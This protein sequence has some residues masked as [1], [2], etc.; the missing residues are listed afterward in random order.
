MSAPLTSLVCSGCGA[1]VPPDEP[2]PFR[3]PAARPGDDVDHV[4]RR[5]LDTGRLA[6]E[7]DIQELF[8][9]PEANP[10]VRYRRLLHS[11]NVARARGMSDQDFVAL[12]RD[13][14]GRVAE[15]DGAGFQ[16]TPFGRSEPLAKRL[17][18]GPEAA[19]W[20][21]DETGNVSGS[22]KG[23]HL[24]GILL[25]LEVAA[26]TGLTGGGKARAR[27]A[28]SSC[29]NAALAAAVTARAAR[30]P[31]EVFVPPDA[32]PR[33]LDRLAALGATVMPCPRAGDTPGDPCYHAFR[34]AVEEGALP[35]S[36]Q[37]NE[38]GLTVEGG[39]TLAWEMVSVLMGEGRTLDRLF[40]Q[41]GGGALAS[42]CMQGFA[43]AFE[44]GLSRRVPALHAVQA[45]GAWPLKRAYDRVAGAV[46]ARRLREGETPEAVPESPAGLAAFLHDEVP[47]E[48]VAAE[49]DHA[50]R[51]RSAFMWPWETAPESIAHGIL[52][53]ET[54]DWRAVT[55]GML[56]SGGFP[57]VVSEDLLTEANEAA[58]IRS[59]ISV[60]PTGSAGFAGALAFRRDPGF[61]PDDEVAVLFT[62]VER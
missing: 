7:V 15:V 8:S 42:A 33:V 61:G 55:E 5:V 21:K 43:E 44:L 29:G 35:F 56:R 60:D 14:N 6:A 59:G 49:L 3:C 36:V 1:A 10:F 52:D 30:M 27:L 38:N 45:L 58:V 25:W 11:Y 47:W 40:V 16:V 62:G 17:G 9:D 41:V 53:D 19:L 28:I 34:R 54:Y 31:L 32:E 57:I 22:H 39:E 48:D 50:A 26:R 12:V 37:G 20:V 2:Y 24:M 13:L 51:H 23:R 4:L 18:L 46:V